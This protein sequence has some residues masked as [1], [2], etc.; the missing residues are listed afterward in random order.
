MSNFELYISQYFDKFQWRNKNSQFST[1]QTNFF[2]YFFV[3]LPRF[4]IRAICYPTDAFGSVHFIEP[5]KLLPKF[6]SCV[7]HD[8][9]PMSLFM[10]TR[11]SSSNCRILSRYIIGQ[12]NIRYISGRY[13]GTI[14]CAEATEEPWKWPLTLPASCKWIIALLSVVWI[15]QAPFKSCTFR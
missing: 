6:P 11:N 2:A 14:H 12:H 13:V 7:R 9:K 10:I 1:E 8:I 15:F 5:P 4:L 3:W